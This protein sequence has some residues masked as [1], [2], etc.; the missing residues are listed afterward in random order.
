MNINLAILFSLVFNLV[1]FLF[2]FKRKKI[3]QIIFG[4]LLLILALSCL[5]FFYYMV[6][7]MQNGLGPGG[8]QEI[9]TSLLSLKDFLYKAGKMLFIPLPFFMAGVLL[10]FMGF[11]ENQNDTHPKNKPLVS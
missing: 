11:R 7:A 4:I 1:F 3:V 8:V 2:L 5:L 6:S 9:E 10:I